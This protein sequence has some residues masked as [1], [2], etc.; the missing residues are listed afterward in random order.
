MI[1]TMTNT[2]RATEIGLVV[3]VGGGGE[4]REPKGR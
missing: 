4:G 3:T 1:K 2:H